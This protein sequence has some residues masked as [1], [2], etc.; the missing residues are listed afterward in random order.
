[1]G[2]DRLKI[3]L[4]KLHYFIHTEQTTVKYNSSYTLLHKLYYWRQE[5]GIDRL[6]ITLNKLHYFIH[7]EQTTVK[8]IVRPIRY[9]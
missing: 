5:V 1:M 8:Y 4:N 9:E 2:I 7:T 3:T 6:K